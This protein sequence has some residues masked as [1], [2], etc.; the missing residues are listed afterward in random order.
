M[1]ADI[2]FLQI[3]VPAPKSILKPAIPLSPLKEIP[4]RKPTR[5]AQSP[6]RSPARKNIPINTN[7]GLSLQNQRISPQPLLDSGADPLGDE[8]TEEEKRKKEK[9]QAIKAR[10]ARRKSLGRLVDKYKI[11]AG[12]DSL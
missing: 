4:A 3:I 7:G 6:T 2:L 10:D 9:E 12:V 5:A 11:V 1:Y 8:E